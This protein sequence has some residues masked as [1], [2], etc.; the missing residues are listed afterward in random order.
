M[1]DRPPSCVKCNQH[2]SIVL[3][4]VSVTGEDDNRP[5]VA[6]SSHWTL[7]KSWNL[8]VRFTP[9]SGRWAERLLLTQ[10]TRLTS[11]GRAHQVGY[12]GHT[13]VPWRF[14]FYID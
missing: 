14:A 3:K 9:E 11:T 12:I 4:Q 5:L 1:E 6:E 2:T 8:S 7:A 10:S 13:S